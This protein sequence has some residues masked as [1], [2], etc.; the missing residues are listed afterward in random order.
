MQYILNCKKRIQERNNIQE[1]SLTKTNMFK[2]PNINIGFAI[3]TIKLYK[4]LQCIHI[5]NNLASFLNNE[6][7]FSSSVH[8]VW[9]HF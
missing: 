7:S 8:V 9:W 3:F 6:W 4:T 1:K 2:G 5:L